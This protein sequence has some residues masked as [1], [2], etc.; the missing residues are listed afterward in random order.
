MRSSNSPRKNPTKGAISG[1]HAMLLQHQ[2]REAPEEVEACAMPKTFQ[3]N[4]PTGNGAVS[5]LINSKLGNPSWRRQDVSQCR[6]REKVFTDRSEEIYSLSSPPLTSQLRSTHNR[7]YAE[8][9]SYRRL[10]HS[11][12]NITRALN[13]NPTHPCQVASPCGDV[14]ISRANRPGRMQPCRQASSGKRCA[15][16][17]IATPNRPNLHPR[18]AFETSKPRIESFKSLAADGARLVYSSPWST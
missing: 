10:R 17:A 4:R 2:A 9:Q 13:A 5:V 11:V 8:V 18:P 14:V 7:E 15:C 1:V 6:R 16:G 12:K 3:Q